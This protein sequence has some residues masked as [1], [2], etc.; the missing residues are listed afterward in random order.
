MAIDKIYVQD[1]HG[2]PIGELSG[3]VVI[4]NRTSSGVRTIPDSPTS[5]V[6]TSSEYNDIY[7]DALELLLSQ[8]YLTTFSG[9]APFA[10]GNFF[11]DGSDCLSWY[12][13]AG[14]LVFVDLCP[15]CDNCE[16]ILILKKRIEYYKLV[17]NA[18]KEANLGYLTDSNDLEN[19]RIAIPAN[20]PEALNHLQEEDFE[21][22]GL[23]LLGQYATTVH[24]WNYVVSQNN[25]STEVSST[26]EDQAGFYVQTKRS[27][28][29]CSGLSSIQCIVEVNLHSG[30]DGLSLFVNTPKTEFMPFKD[31][32]AV[33]PNMASIDHVGFTTKTVTTAF[34]PS[35]YAGTYS[36]QVK[37]LPFIF[38][39]ILNYLGNVVNI[40]DHIDS[41]GGRIEKG[42][43]SYRTEQVTHPTER[44][45]NEAKLYPSKSSKINNIWQ[46][47]VRWVLS[48]ALDKEY[49]N[50]YYYECNGVR[51]Y[52]SGILTPPVD[53]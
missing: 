50:T 41:G 42:E 51:E 25:A 46:I 20:C 18:I 38:S 10:D 12:S 13:A 37:F 26:P 16:E 49:S 15:S 19:A 17:F 22:K 28:P 36:L 14:D 35:E 44:D 11:I 43:G 4:S 52:M 27:F 8:R 33:T 3:S 30:Q 23:A 9:I 2:N 21:I 45:Y 24:M 31:N 47:T 32:T 1:L 6:V 7:S 5:V 40:R 53:D 48:G 34:P 29:S 39:E